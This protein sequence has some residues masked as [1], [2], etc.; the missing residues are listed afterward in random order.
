MNIEKNICNV[1][2][3]LLDIDGKIKDTLKARHDL[4]VMRIHKDLHLQQNSTFT[5]I[6][7]ANDTLSKT[8]KKYLRLVERCEI[9]LYMS[10]NNMT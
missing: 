9:P 6:P 4:C 5:S 1:L 2:G 7:H 8:K 3:K 10:I